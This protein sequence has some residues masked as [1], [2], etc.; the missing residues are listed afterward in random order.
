MT[1][2]TNML[3]GSG[4]YSGKL[5]H[6]MQPHGMGTYTDEFGNQ[7]YGE[8]HAGLQSG[9]FKFSYKYGADEEAF[10]SGRCLTFEDSGFEWACA[11]KNS[12]LSFEGVRAE[13]HRDIHGQTGIFKVLDMAGIETIEA[14]I[15]GNRLTEQD[16]GDKWAFAFKCQFLPVAAP[17]ASF[18][19]APVR[20]KT[21]VKNRN[22]KKSKRQKRDACAV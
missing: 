19:A 1:H 21:F 17:L 10:L 7:Q 14:F 16:S 12:F 9:I 5:N 2:V 6:H 13:V 20:G 4:N 8:W 15:K 22:Q 11:I 3:L 18:V